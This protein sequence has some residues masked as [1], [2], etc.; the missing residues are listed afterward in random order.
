MESQQNSAEIY[1]QWIRAVPHQLI[2][3]SIQSYTGVNLSDPKQRNELVFPLFKHNMYVIDYW[4]SNMVF[5]REAKTFEHKLMCTAFDL[6]SDNF[7][8]TVSGFSGTNDT[9]NILPL[10]ITQND[11]KELER[12]NDNVRNILLREENSRYYPLP[13]NVR[14]LEILIKMSKWKIPVLLDAGACMLELNNEQVARQWLNFVDPALY[15]ATVYF[16]S[17]DVL[18]TMDRNGIIT[19]F[20]YSVYRN[21]LDR[22]LVY[23]DDAHTRGTDLKFPLGWKACVTISA[24]ITRDKTVQACMRMRLLG[25]G[26]SIV[27]VASYEADV[28]IREFCNLGNSRRTNKHV[29]DF[30]CDNSRRFEEE[31]IVH[32]SAA[33]Y[34][35]TKKLVAH[36]LYDDSVDENATQMLHAKVLDNEY[37][38]L[39]DMYG[40]KETAL[41]TQISKSQFE[42]LVEANATNEDILKLIR[43]V[44]DGV[45]R[46]LVK[47][48]STLRRFTQVLDEEQEK[49]LEHELEEQ[50][51]VERPPP[52]LASIPIYDSLLENIVTNGATSLGFRSMV[53][54][55]GL[56]SLDASFTD[57]PMYKA[58]KNE[59]PWSENLFV[60]NDFVRVVEDQY[61]E[62]FLR[63]IWWIAHVTH[64]TGDDV[65]I[66][67]S[68]FE[69]DKLLPFFRKSTRSALLSYRPRL[70]Q[71]HSNLLHDLQ[72]QVSGMDAN[73]DNKIGLDDEVQIAMYA[74]AMYFTSEAEQNAYCGFL[75]LIPQPRPVDLEIAYDEGY[76]S[77]NGYVLP[78]NRRHSSAIARC[79]KKCKFIQNP[80]E[81]AIKIIES[82]HVFI[83]KESHAA[84]ILEK[85]KKENI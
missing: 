74:G 7:V 80:V 29:I 79:V 42:K 44:N 51:Q 5:P 49:E 21:K 35:Y 58:H 60:T 9:K 25:K 69:V 20:D 61:S 11:L 68:S 67:L 10:P 55:K 31:N 13:A 71:G 46:K 56:M 3:E 76:I 2:D 22:C 16:N 57:K 73:S 26:H 84:A 59:T 15:D 50:R 38:T 82:H 6:V 41:L 17:A 66:L 47:Q 34:N 32:W 81:L 48:A 24:D 52:A 63:P 85:C 40:V 75:G 8:H 37:V 62:E 19:E 65:F 30:I 45:N 39:K 72:L 53:N 43:F 64:R 14:G 77:P 27:F 83:R 1:E 33:A 54:S 4:L 23:L 78:E 28:R 70:S 12:T 36:K 18:M